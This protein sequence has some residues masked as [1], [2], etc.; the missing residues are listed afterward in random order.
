MFENEEPRS[1]KAQE[2]HFNKIM[3]HILL[4]SVNVLEAHRS[5]SEYIL[6]MNNKIAST[7]SSVV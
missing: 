6:N 1:K 2:R 4:K 5:I 7:I 3:R